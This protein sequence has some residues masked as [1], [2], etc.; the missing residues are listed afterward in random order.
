MKHLKLF[1]NN[2]ENEVLNVM[3]AYDDMCDKIRDFINFE[4]NMD[5][6][7]VIRYYYETD[8]DKIGDK[9]L[10][11]EYGKLRIDNTILPADERVFVTT[12]LTSLYSFIDNPE[13]YKKTNQ[14]NL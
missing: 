6:Q 10:I 14:Y 7:H 2:S 9:G 13:L 5:T 11:V 1:E 4:Y 12:D 8:I 3:N